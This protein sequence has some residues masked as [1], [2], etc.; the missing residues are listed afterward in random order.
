MRRP[1]PIRLPLVL[2]AAGLAW[3]GCASTQTPPPPEFVGGAWDVVVAGTPEGDLEGVLTVTPLADSLAGNVVFPALGPPQ[4]LEEVT[5]EDGRLAF[6]AT[7][8]FNA[9][10]TLV[11]GSAALDGDRIEGQVEV[12]GVGQFELS[13]TRTTE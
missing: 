10:P 13:G 12:P 6:S 2:L 5:Y 3:A 9:L 8:E 4:P 7:F 1:L 11:L